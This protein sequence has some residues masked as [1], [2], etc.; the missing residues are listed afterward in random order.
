MLCGHPKA[1]LTPTNHVA[2]LPTTHLE[3]PNNWARTQMQ[4][5]KHGGLLKLLKSHPNVH[6]ITHCWFHNA[7]LFWAP[8]S[9][10]LVF[11]TPSSVS[12]A[13]RARGGIPHES[14]VTA[15]TAGRGP[16]LTDADYHKGPGHGW[17]P[18]TE[19]GYKCCP[20][21]DPLPQTG[22]KKLSRGGSAPAVCAA[23]AC[24]RSGVGT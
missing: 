23:V 10:L 18:A 17:A 19:P 24:R 13:D 4:C 9:V 16:I 11:S 7:R 1:A 2:A 3:F 12:N 21:A 15:C 14:A 20:R 6:S 8:F 22:R 5:G